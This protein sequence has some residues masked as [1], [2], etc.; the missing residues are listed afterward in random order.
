MDTTD[1]QQILVKHNSFY[2]RVY[3]YNAQL[4][5]LESKALSSSK[6]LGNLTD[7]NYDDP[8]LSNIDENSHPILTENAESIQIELPHQ[9]A[10]NSLQNKEMKWP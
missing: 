2:V 3:L 8:L 10:E 7:I 6:S 1:G 4:R 9:D 5:D